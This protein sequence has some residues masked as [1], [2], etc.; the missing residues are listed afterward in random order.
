LPWVRPRR[1]GPEPLATLEQLL[2]RLPLVTRQLRWRQGPEPPFRVDDERDLEDLVRSILPLHFDEV[3]LESRT[4]GYSA[5]NRTDLLLAPGKIAITMKCAGPDKG[6]AQLL[7]Q[8]QEDTAYHRQRGGCRT[9]FNYLHDPECLMREHQ[10]LE[11]L[12][13]SRDDEFEVRCVVGQCGLPA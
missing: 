11:S 6:E 5:V 1:V 9:L 7:N 8:W 3:R 2:R 4:P 13:S 10:R 12:G